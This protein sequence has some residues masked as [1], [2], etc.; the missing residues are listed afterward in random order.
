[1][2]FCKVYCN[3][4]LNYNVLV[5]RNVFIFWGVEKVCVF[6]LVVKN[7]YLYILNIVIDIIILKSFICVF[8]ELNVWVLLWLLLEIGFYYNNFSG[9]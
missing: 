4:F 5:I 8:C 7:I 6:K 2:L 3:K 9:I 1:M